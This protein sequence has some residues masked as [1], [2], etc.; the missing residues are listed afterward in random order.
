MLTQTC[1]VDMSD[2]A[3]LVPALPADPLGA[4]YFDISGGDKTDE[5]I[6]SGQSLGRSG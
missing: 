2:M 5:G 1:C 6:D 3:Q 4:G